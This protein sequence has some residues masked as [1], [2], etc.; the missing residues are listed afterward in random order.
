MMHLL[1][2]LISFVLALATVYKC[3]VVATTYSVTTHYADS[4]TSCDGT[5]YRIEVNEDAECSEAECAASTNGLYDG[6][7][8]S[9]CTND[10]KNEV[11]KRFGSSVYLLQAV[12]HDDVCSNFAYARAYIANGKCEVGSTT[13]WFTARIET[14]GSAT[15]NHFT[16][17]SC[18]PDDLFLS[19]ERASK[20]NLDSNACD[21]NNE[22]Q[23]FTN[24]GSTAAPLVSST[25][26]SSSSSGG[27]DSDATS[28]SG[29]T[30]TTSPATKSD[31]TISDDPAASRSTATTDN[32]STSSSGDG[33][34]GLGVGAIAGIVIAGV[35]AVAM[36]Y[37][38]IFHRDRPI[39]ITCF[40]AS[41]A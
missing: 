39:A 25:T 36:V 31:T 29:T 22:Y 33:D 40:S 30:T 14:N 4:D 18:S 17:E 38:I 28:S 13:S 21:A 16:T 1:V 32:T 3:S 34:S 19:T 15:L 7:A 37:A 41:V 6:V 5:P 23:W 11:W 8:S 35:V 24:K 2:V 10:Y 12:Y 26:T 9:I 27:G 20:A